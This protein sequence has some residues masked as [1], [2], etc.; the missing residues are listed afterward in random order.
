MIPMKAGPVEMP[1]KSPSNH[2]LKGTIAA[3]GMAA[4]PVAIVLE[5]ALHYARATCDEPQ[6]EIERLERALKVSE[7][8]LLSIQ[9][10]LEKEGA[11]DEAQIIG[12][13]CPH[14][15]R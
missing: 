13:R 9:S 10:N 5:D 4:G 7:R 12:A 6:V 11:K 1:F 2:R 14:P 15:A 8:E 3:P